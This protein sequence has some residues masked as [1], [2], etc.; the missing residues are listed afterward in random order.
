MTFRVGMSTMV[1]GL[2]TTF[3]DERYFQGWKGNHWSMV[4]INVSWLET[5]YMVGRTT[6]VP[7][8][9]TAFMDEY[10]LHG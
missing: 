5:T 9:E 8:L 6:N 7:W 2:K 1:S 10:N 4:G 3:M